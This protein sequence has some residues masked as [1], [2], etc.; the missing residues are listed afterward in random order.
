MAT[1]T[2]KQRRDRW[3]NLTRGLEVPR[4]RKQDGPPQPPLT[5]EQAT[6]IYNVSETTPSL[7][8][9]KDR[10]IQYM[11]EYSET[12]RPEERLPAEELIA[13][14]SSVCGRELQRA[15]R[16]ILPSF[17]ET[18]LFAVLYG[19]AIPL[20][21]GYKDT[22]ASHFEVN[23]KNE[24][25]GLRHPH[26]QRQIECDAYFKQKQGEKWRP[27][28]TEVGYGGRKKRKTKKISKKSKKT[29]RRK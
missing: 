6:K 7:N 21:A 3:M 20:V 8:P 18:E 13:Q 25:I 29:L 9:Y 23:S 19:T 17:S 10:I 22:Y 14:A 24:I 27:S 2:P 15:G 11:V 28:P 26:Q 12:L 16:T 4:Y 1:E 5:K